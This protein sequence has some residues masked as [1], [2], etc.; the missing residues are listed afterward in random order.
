MENNNFSDFNGMQTSLPNASAVLILGIISIPVC[1]CYGILSIIL[2]IIALVLAK[3][4]EK[5]YIATPENYLASSYKN[6]KA[7][8]ICAIIGLILGI[9][10]I[11]LVV[12]VILI[13]GLS[14]LSDPAQIQEILKQY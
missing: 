3:N 14:A 5:L 2:A 12:V 11:I 10:Y 13:F 4:A 7:G 6:L 9:A 8:K 1:C